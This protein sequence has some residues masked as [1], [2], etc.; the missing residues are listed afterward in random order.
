MKLTTLTAAALIAY[1]LMNAASAGS[2]E[3]GTDDPIVIEPVN[4]CNWWT[5]SCHT[6]FDFDE[7]EG[8]STVPNTTPQPKPEKP[9]NP[10]KTVQVSNN[11]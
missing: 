7:P 3:L 5:F 10:C 2:Y 6:G 4:T 1:G 9:K 11:C 8:D